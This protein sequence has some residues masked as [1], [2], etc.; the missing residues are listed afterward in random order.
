[1]TKFTVITT[2]LLLSSVAIYAQVPIKVIEV[3]S[4]SLK[5]NETIPFD[6]EFQLKIRFDSEPEYVELIK[7][8]GR[9]NWVETLKKRTKGT[10][11]YT[12]PQIPKTNFE[13][14]KDGGKNYLFIKFGEHQTTYYKKFN[15]D[16]TRYRYKKSKSSNDFLKPGSAYTILL[17]KPR[18]KGFAIFDKID[19]GDQTGAQTSIDE[20]YD[21]DA[22]ALGGLTYHIKSLSKANAFYT[23]SLQQL[24]S[25]VAAER[26]AIDK[27][28]T[29]YGSVQSSTTLKDSRNKLLDS[30]V[31]EVSLKYKDTKMLMVIYVSILKSTAAQITKVLTGELSLRKIG[32]E[33][34]DITVSK[35][36]NNLQ[37]SIEDLVALN[38]FINWCIDK[39]WIITGTNDLP[40]LIKQMGDNKTHLSEIAKNT[41]LIRKAI[42]ENGYFVEPVVIEGNS[43]IYSFETRNKLQISPDFGYTV[44]GF[45]KGFTGF[46][47]Y[48]GFHVNFRYIDK[49]IPFSIFKKFNRYPN[50]TVWHYLSFMTAWT[51]AS[52]DKENK[53]ENFFENGAL[54]TG[55]G[56]RI[57][58]SV[59]IVGGNLWFYKQNPVSAIK[60]RK[61]AITPFVGL[62]LDLSLKSLMNDITSLKPTR[63]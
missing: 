35:Q 39:S 31:A 27:S 53:R 19:A 16:S 14:R 56:L 6:K 36:I 58:H 37:E 28:A 9:R 32:E 4:I 3:D 54:M 22:D 11:A 44:Y 23:S 43:Y 46:T 30:K 29:K 24:Y 60:D 7:N 18:E 13:F 47:P 12:I 17:P 40:T 61:L 25:T 51:L 62:S 42:I 33:D 55:F 48:L 41:T 10:Y 26:T 8:D 63:E 21:A 57:S 38:E 50:K 15:L 59:R 49:D 2:L 45:Q 5:P 34:K 20:L 52:I 1:M